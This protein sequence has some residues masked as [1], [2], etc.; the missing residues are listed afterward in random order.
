MKFIETL[1]LKSKLLI[2]FIS[3][4][5]ALVVLGLVGAINTQAMKS[6]IDALYF[7]T[8]IPTSELHKIIYIYNGDLLA[9]LYRAKEGLL[10]KEEFEQRVQ[11][12]LNE[13]KQL[14][15]SY[16]QHYK[17]DEELAYIEYASREIEQ[18]NWYFYKVLAASKMQ[19][20]L[21]KISI[22]FFERNI[23]HINSVIKELINYELLVAKTDRK[24]FLAYYQHTI[25]S[26]GII[27]VLIIISMVFILY[28]VFKSIQREHTKLEIASEKLKKANEQ[29]QNA[30][31]TD[32][33]TT[34]HNRR[35]FNYIYEKELKRAKREKRYITFMMID[36]DFFKQYNDTY[37]HVA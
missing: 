3:V 8:L 1:R 10:P 2:L 23:Q 29:L 13:I 32:Y 12:G 7:R 16:A 26:M 14:W 31:Y 11:N 17:S 22:L 27:L 4:T 37:G 6:R 9:L 33:L 5:I 15:S 25:K 20:D 28:Y 19:K 35:Y 30:S 21:K 36:I 34:L 18:T 24:R